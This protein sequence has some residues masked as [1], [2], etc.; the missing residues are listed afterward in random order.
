MLADSNVTVQQA[1]AAVDALAVAYDKL[2]DVYSY[3][4]DMIVEEFGELVQ[5]LADDE[6]T[7]LGFAGIVFCGDE[8]AFDYGFES[9][10]GDGGDGGDGNGGDGGDGGDGNGGEEPREFQRSL[11]QVWVLLA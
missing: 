11:R 7:T 10:G 2:T 6:L 3:Q 9:G 4:I 5:D 8:E 1:E